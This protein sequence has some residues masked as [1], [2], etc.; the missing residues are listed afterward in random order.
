MNKLRA[1]LLSLP[2]R[3]TGSHIETGQE[4]LTS[5]SSR[6]KFQVSSELERKQ[7]ELKAELD[8]R[9]VKVI[10]RMVESQP[11]SFVR[12]LSLPDDSFYG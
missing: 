6:A 8:A 2:H 12:T 11:D 3:I 1:L 4:R 10:G 7:R 9:G 5:I